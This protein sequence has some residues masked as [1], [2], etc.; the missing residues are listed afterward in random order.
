M[1][2]DP[3][4]PYGILRR[5]AFGEVSAAPTSRGV[6]GLWLGRHCLYVGKA[7][8]I[9]HRL[10]QHWNGSHNPTLR[11][12]LRV[13]AEDIHFAVCVLPD[14]VNLKHVEDHFIAKFDPVTNVVKPRIQK[15]DHAICYP[16]TTPEDI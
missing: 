11:L 13:R 3:T 6:Y 5:F 7:S 15:N 2:S 9:R 16:P 4:C 14:D 12:W 10:T 8:D 1:S